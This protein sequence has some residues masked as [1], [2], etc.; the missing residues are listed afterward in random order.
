MAETCRA[1]VISKFN[2]P[3]EIRQV[4]IP[5]LE[6]GG[7]L[8]RVEAATLC[9]T[10]VHR[11]HGSLGIA[12]SLPFIPGHETCGT[13]TEIKGS[14]T[15][16]LG[17]PLERGDRVLWAYPSCGRCYYC[18]VARQHTLCAEKRSWG[19]QKIDEYPYLLGGL[20]EY[21]YAPPTSAVITVPDGVSSPLAASAACALRTV[22]SGFE[23]L[24]AIASHE[25]VVV[26]GAGPLGLYATAVARDHGAHRVLVAGAPTA[27]LSVAKQLGGDAVLN[28]EELSDP[29][30]R[31]AWVRDQTD[32]RG[33][34]VVIQV[35]SGESVGEG[36]Q[37]V[38]PGGRY[39]SIGGGGS[40]AV[41][42]EALGRGISYVNI[43][44]AE[45]RHWLQAVDFLASRRSL[46]FEQIITGT[47]SLE[48]ASEA[49]RLMAEYKIV[50]PV[51]QP[52]G[53]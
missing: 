38:R 26:Q 30:D 25:T 52:Q 17:R 27:R 3:L 32:G 43:Q 41:P 19:H 20:A 2:E 45:P 46:P 15:D 14:R 9:G 23:R 22:M 5:D 36:L 16:L 48:G 50:K 40:H 24:G 7:M 13:V 11:W 6:N 18:T 21:Q 53:A 29:K 8:A 42:L 12:G 44:Q 31:I 33:G 51:I 1:A 4:Q 47:Y 49:F 39:V 35:A 28:I 37:M 34:D 10:D